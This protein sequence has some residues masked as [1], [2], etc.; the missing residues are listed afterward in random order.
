M[1]GT[2]KYLVTMIPMMIDALIEITYCVVVLLIA[3][4]TS[5]SL[6]ALMFPCPNINPA[7]EDEG[8]VCPKNLGS[9][10]PCGTH[11]RLK[12][13]DHLVLSISER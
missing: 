9:W 13:R 3:F 10:V 5:K 7:R 1:H 2:T 12:Y 8:G 11:L 6:A 4:V